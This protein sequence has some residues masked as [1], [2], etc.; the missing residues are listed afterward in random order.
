MNEPQGLITQLWPHLRLPEPPPIRLPEAFC[1]ACMDDLE[2]TPA[3]F[4]C[5]HCGTRWPYLARNRDL[6]ELDPDANGPK[7]SH[8]YAV[9]VASQRKRTERE[10]TYR[11]TGHWPA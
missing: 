8:A 9:E 11:A 1:G 3:G 6:G 5:R 7:V 4:H 10:N 2:R